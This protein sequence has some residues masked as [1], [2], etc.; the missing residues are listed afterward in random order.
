[1]STVP[2][3]TLVGSRSKHE[4]VALQ[5]RGPLTFRGVR[6]YASGPAD[7]VSIRAQ[8]RQAYLDKSEYSSGCDE[9]KRCEAWGDE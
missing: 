3:H 8:Q 1:M 5:A 6:F 4:K 7:P 2:R 9:R